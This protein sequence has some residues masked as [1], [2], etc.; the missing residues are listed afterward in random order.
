MPFGE[1]N[2]SPDFLETEYSS[3]IHPPAKCICR[4]NILRDKVDVLKQ[5]GHGIF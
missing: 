5:Q 2:F 3:V 1:G 4:I